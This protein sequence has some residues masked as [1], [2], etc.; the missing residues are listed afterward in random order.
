MRR[1][2]KTGKY[3]SGITSAHRLCCIGQRQAPRQSHSAMNSHHRRFPTFDTLSI[4]IYSW[5]WAAV[6]VTLIAACLVV[7]GTPLPKAPVLVMSESGGSMA[8]DY[9]ELRHRVEGT[10]P[11]VR[12]TSDTAELLGRGVAIGIAVRAAR[13]AEQGEVSHRRSRRTSA[14]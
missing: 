8:N 14:R 12:V 6:S 7:L 3:G 9:V 4:D 13:R 1:A 2:I 5:V 11:A 10:L